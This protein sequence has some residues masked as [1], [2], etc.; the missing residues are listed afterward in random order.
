MSLSSF[1]SELQGHR[2]SLDS[3]HTRSIFL[4]Q[5]SL[6][7]VPCADNA[8]F[9]KSLFRFQL[10]SHFLQKVFPELYLN[11]LCLS[12]FP[13]LKAL[14]TF[15][16]IAF[17]AMYD[18]LVSLLPGLWAPGWQRL[19]LSCSTLQDLQCLAEHQA[20]D[21]GSYQEEP[22]RL[23]KR[24]ASDLFHQLC[25]ARERMPELMLPAIGVFT[26]NKTFTQRVK[27]E[28]ISFKPQVTNSFLHQT[29]LSLEHCNFK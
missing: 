15:H 12:S 7:T 26:L 6:H 17:I 9:P 24:K 27:K 20:L 5:H 4:L 21:L 1:L 8:L 18:W 16:F 28:R 13:T 2:L 10:T 19:S 3:L 22:H 14:W 23:G 11:Y 29:Q 25:L